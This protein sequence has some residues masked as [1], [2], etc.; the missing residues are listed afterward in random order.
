MVPLAPIAAGD[1]PAMEPS[2]RSPSAHER[3][4]RIAIRRESRS[5]CVLNEVPT[6]PISKAALP[7]ERPG[8]KRADGKRADGKKKQNA[9]KGHPPGT[10]VEPQRQGPEL[11]RGE[12]RLG[13]GRPCFR[14][15]A[16]EPGEARPPREHQG[17]Y[18][19]SGFSAGP[20]RCPR[21]KRPQR[22]IALMEGP[23]AVNRTRQNPPTGVPATQLPAHRPIPPAVVYRAGAVSAISI[24]RTAPY[25]RARAKPH[26]R[27]DDE[28][29]G[30]A[31]RRGR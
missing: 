2:G 13:F 14:V 27:A 11:G 5:F 22:P 7:G 4:R 29:N 9:E 31:A 30:K 26:G 18:D 23:V 21:A 6:F 28:I 10:A 25:S 12:S 3:W 17:Q 20:V 1:G 19:Q 24:T 16:P 15:A 8:G